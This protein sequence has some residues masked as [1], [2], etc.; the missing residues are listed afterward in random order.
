MWQRDDIYTTDEQGR[1][2]DRQGYVMSIS[3]LAKDTVYVILE[4]D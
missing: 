1:F 4:D 3:T 2:T